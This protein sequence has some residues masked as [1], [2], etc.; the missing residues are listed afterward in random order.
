MTCWRREECSRA[1]E[2]CFCPQ[3]QSKKPQPRSE[4]PNT[5]WQRGDE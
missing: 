5:R 1:E 2:G 3:W 4:D